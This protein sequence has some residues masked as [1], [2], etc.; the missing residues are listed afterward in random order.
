MFLK[1]YWKSNLF[2]VFL[3]FIFT[4]FDIYIN[5]YPMPIYK[6]LIKDYF[7]IN[8]MSYIGVYF[9]FTYFMDFVVF[10]FKKLSK[11]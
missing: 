5:N 4:L 7:W 2:F 3:I 9:A 10:L 8:V 1:K 6:N 11:K